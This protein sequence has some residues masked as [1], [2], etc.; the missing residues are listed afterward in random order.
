MRCAHLVSAAVRL[1]F[2]PHDVAASADGLLEVLRGEHGVGRRCGRWQPD[3]CVSHCT[4]AGL[5]LH[6]HMTPEL[7][8]QIGASSAGM[9]PGVAEMSTRDCCCPRVCA[10]ALNRLSTAGTRSI[11]RGR[12][13]QQMWASPAP[14]ASSRVGGCGHP[15]SLT[16]ARPAVC[17]GCNSSRRCTAH[18][19]Q[20][21]AGLA[22]CLSKTVKHGG[23]MSLYNGFGVSVQVRYILYVC[24]A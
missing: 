16:S 22:D 12:G 24:A 2:G 17:T 1:S 5:R 10:G 4:L 6:G 14:I 8:S 18:G 23:V 13:W 20:P 3:L 9:W 19:R 11:M 7:A 21:A 15:A